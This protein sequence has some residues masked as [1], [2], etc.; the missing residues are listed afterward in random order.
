MA[1]NS[2]N[3]G[4]MLVLALTACA[5]HTS[6]SPSDGT[7]PSI[8]QAERHT[9]ASTSAS[10]VT[11]TDLGMPPGYSNSV[12]ESLGINNSGT[13][14]GT[15]CCTPHT[16]GY[17]ETGGAFTLLKV[18]PPNYTESIAN[19]LSVSGIIGGRICQANFNTCLPAFWSSATAAPTI[20][21]TRGR[22]W[23]G[24]VDSINRYGTMVG[25][26]YDYYDDQPIHAWAWA[27][28]KLNDL[29]IGQANG[30]NDA[31]QVVGTLSDPYPNEAVFYLGLD[32]YKLL[33]SLAPGKTTGA[34]AI[35]NQG[36]V[37]GSGVIHNP[38]SF[39]PFIYKDGKMTAIPVP[40]STTGG[41]AAA[42]NDSGDVVGFYGTPNLAYGHAF[43]YSNGAFT[44]LNNL[45][46]P[47]SGWVLEEGTG[48]NDSGLIVGTGLHNGQ[49]AAFLLRRN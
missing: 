12:F 43:L 38:N 32:R 25:S 14:F 33:G 8:S 47:G 4:C 17:V 31:A 42:V 41:A 30:I 13:I 49:R 5:G 27:N 15:V 22:Y 23:S 1:L 18:D 40:I 26:G 35:N 7:L 44:D 29:G 3:L 28:G 2:R 6:S 10:T 36:I 48:I 45:L 21:P 37:V 34:A 19:A 11:V 24:Y 20:L 16:T 9:E 39:F 46:P